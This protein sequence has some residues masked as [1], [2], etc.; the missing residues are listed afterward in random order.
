MFHGYL[1]HYLFAKCYE[2]WRLTLWK[3]IDENSFNSK[4]IADIEM[5]CPIIWLFYF[6][7]FKMDSKFINRE[8]AYTILHFIVNCSIFKL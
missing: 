7:L 8:P 2:Y 4:T 1:Y 6:A 5:V 3:H